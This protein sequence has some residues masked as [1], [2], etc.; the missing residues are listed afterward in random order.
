MASRA[1]SPAEV[2]AYRRV[3]DEAI[4][5][6]LIHH[7]PRCIG[8][9]TDGIVDQVNR[10][11]ASPAFQRLR[12]IVDERLNVYKN[13]N[14]VGCPLI[15][16]RRVMVRFE[17]DDLASLVRHLIIGAQVRIEE[18]Y[19]GD[20]FSCPSLVG[21]F[22]QFCDDQSSRSA[23]IDVN[24][25]AAILLSRHQQVACSNVMGWLRNLR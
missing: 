19:G 11:C 20:Y 13:Q 5:R 8:I 25:L 1:P 21:K 18:L 24:A 7:T 22:I 3:I 15:G 6:R 23:P 4:F 9:R 10:S 14:A 16:L 2:E 12:S 17:R